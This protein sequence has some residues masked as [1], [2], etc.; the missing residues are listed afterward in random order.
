MAV[1]EFLEDL[2]GCRVDLV[3]ESAIKPRLREVIMRETVHATG[4]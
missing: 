2:F 1:K 4:L 3:I